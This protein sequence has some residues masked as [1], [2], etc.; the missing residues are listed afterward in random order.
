MEIKINWTPVLY[1]PA[2]QL[3]SVRNDSVHVF[4]HFCRLSTRA[5]TQRH[6]YLTGD[7]TATEQ[8][9]ITQNF[10]QNNNNCD[11]RLV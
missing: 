9:L 10:T 1:F 8:M 5:K 3:V 6:R 2:H 11:R 4:V 7:K